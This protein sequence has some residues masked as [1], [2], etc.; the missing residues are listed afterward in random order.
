M[1]ELV[2]LLAGLDT[3]KAFDRVW[4]AG[5]LHKLISDG[6]S[7]KIFGLIASFLEYCCHSLAVAIC[8]VELLD[9]VQRRICKNVGTSLA[10]PL[11]LMVHRGNVASV[12]LFRRYYFGI[13]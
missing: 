4:H 11:E 2:G 8:Y 10:T 1:V 6:I 9:K 7:G 3:S 12:S 5:L 13:C